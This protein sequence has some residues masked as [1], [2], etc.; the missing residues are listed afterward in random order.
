VPTLRN[1]A[2]TAPYMHNGYFK[3]L[4]DVVEFYVTR[5]TNASKWYPADVNGHVQKFNDLPEIYHGNVNT[6]EAPYDRQPGDAPRLNGSEIDYV[7]AF[8]NTLSDGYKR[9]R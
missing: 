4:R 7:V 3:S 8:L 5:D 1:V 9:A 6:S 2:K